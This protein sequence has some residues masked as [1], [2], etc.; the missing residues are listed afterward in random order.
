[1]LAFLQ[2]NNS[3]RYDMNNNHKLSINVSNLFFQDIQPPIL[4]VESTNAQIE[5]MVGPEFINNPLPLPLYESIRDVL[6]PIGKDK[7]GLDVKPK[8]LVAIEDSYLHF[9]FSQS[10]VK[11]G[12]LSARAKIDRIKHLHTLS[13]SYNWN[14]IGIDIPKMKVVFEI[15]I[16]QLVLTL[17][18]T[19]DIKLVDLNSIEYLDIKEIFKQVV[20]KAYNNSDISKL[21]VGVKTTEQL[22]RNISKLDGDLQVDKMRISQQDTLIEAYTSLLKNNEVL[23][24]SGFNSNV[25]SSSLIDGANVFTSKSIQ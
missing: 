7:I 24:F 16:E 13:E 9:C 10:L 3:Y 6:I 12:S 2:I 14:E 11:S 19:L 18:S 25:V 1:M 4:D 21:A 8:I 20:D 23:S 17:S 22:T 15:V 5:L